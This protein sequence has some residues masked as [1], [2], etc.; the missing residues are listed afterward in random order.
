M[1]APPAYVCPHHVTEFTRSR[2]A[3]TARTDEESDFPVIDTPGVSWSDDLDAY[4]ARFDDGDS[5]SVT[6]AETLEAALDGSFDPLFD[7]V[8][9]DALDA[10]VGGPSATAT[11]EVEDATVTVHGDGRVLVRV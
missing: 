11:F 9:P 4:T 7:Y 10:L 3:S 6:V 8:D 1:V 2:H 5:P